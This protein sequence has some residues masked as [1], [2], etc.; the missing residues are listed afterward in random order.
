MNFE[1]WWKCQK[2]N[3][4]LKKH[5]PA[6]YTNLTIAKE[7]WEA[8]RENQEKYQQHDFCRAVKCENIYNQTSCVVSSTLLCTFSAKEFC[9]WL[10]DNGYKV[11]KK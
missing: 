10:K 11:V 5:E 3:A 1:E 4:F 9:A 7:A 6:K 8:S 2:L